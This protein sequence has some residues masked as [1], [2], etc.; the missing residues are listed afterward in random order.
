VLTKNSSV[1]LL[2]GGVQPYNECPNSSYW[3]VAGRVKLEKFEKNGTD[4]LKEQTAADA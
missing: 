4:R 1:Q 2:W 3:I